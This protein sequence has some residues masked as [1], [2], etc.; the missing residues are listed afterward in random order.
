MEF[1]LQRDFIRREIT[2]YLNDKDNRN[3]AWTSLKCRV[4]DDCLFWSF[5]LDTSERYIDTLNLTRCRQIK[6]RSM[7]KG[8]FVD[9]F[10][11]DDDYG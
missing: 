1:H 8:A 10:Y 11:S 4:V 7:L 5:N 3:L 2:S 9:P 6:D